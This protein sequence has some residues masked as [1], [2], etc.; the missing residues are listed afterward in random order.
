MKLKVL[1]GSGRKIGLLALPFLVIGLI[2]NII[3]PSVFSVGGPP[4]VLLWISVI[5]LIFGVV[6]L[7]MVSF[8][9]FDKDTQEA[10]NYQRALRCHEAPAVYGRCFARFAVAGFSFEHMARRFDRNRH[11]YWFQAVFA[12]RR[13]NTL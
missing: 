2:L 10:V 12:R 1:V 4:I 9:D 8:F 5:V 7:D 3:F 6:N 11:L 13:A